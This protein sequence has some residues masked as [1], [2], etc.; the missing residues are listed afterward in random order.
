MNIGLCLPS[1]AI[2]NAM[3]REDIIRDLQ[4]IRDSIEPQVCIGDED[5]IFL[6]D[7]QQGMKAGIDIAIAEL[8]KQR[9]VQTATYVPPQ[10]TFVVINENGGWHDTNAGIIQA[11]SYREAVVKAS[12]RGW[13]VE[14]FGAGYRMEQMYG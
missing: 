9:P 14:G 4:G 13:T 10:Y 6:T 3:N 12:Q 5:S 2:L 7:Y 1:S 8:K 11:S